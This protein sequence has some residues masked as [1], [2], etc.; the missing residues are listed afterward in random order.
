VGLRNPLVLAE[1]RN[2][3]RALRP[4]ILVYL[5]APRGRLKAYRDAMFFRACGIKKLVGVP[6][7]AD[8]QN[9]RWLPEQE[10]FEYEAERLAR[11][12][13]ELGD[14]RLDDPASW[15]LRISRKEAEKPE[16]FL[17]DIG[18]GKIICCAPGAKVPAKHWGEGNWQELLG[19][20]Y[21]KYPD[22]ALVF[23]GAGNEF[24]ECERAGMNWQGRKLNLCGKLTPRQSVVVLEKADMFIGH[25]SGP[26]HLAASVLTPCVA[27]FSARNKPKVWFPYGHKH[28]VIYHKT[29]CHGCGLEVCEEQGKKCIMSITVDE[30]ER[31]GEEIL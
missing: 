31:A 30:V 26:M 16:Q 13:S 1:L 17:R 29:D 4:D 8:L 23:I 11:C 24:A 6:Y 18:E 21:K 9:N 2:R 28:K 19:R 7:S 25:D 12:L 3:I 22:V 14:A 20:L 15:D 27:I 5:A 10:C